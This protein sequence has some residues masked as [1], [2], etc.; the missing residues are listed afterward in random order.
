MVGHQF[1]FH[2]DILS[3]LLEIVRGII[4]IIIINIIIIIIIIII[5]IC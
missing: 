5:Q 3:V 2:C 1:L 4:I